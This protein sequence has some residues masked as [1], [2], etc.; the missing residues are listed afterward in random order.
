MRI[1]SPVF[2]DGEPLPP[3]YTC[4]GEGIHPELR[5]EEVP[6]EAKSL[7]LIVE[8]PDAPDGPFA[9][10]LLWNIHPMIESIPAGTV[11][12]DAVEGMN[13]AEKPGWHP[14]CP[15]TGDGTHH[16]RFT[17]YA[18]K[19]MLD[20]P[21]DVPRETFDAEIASHLIDTASLTATYAR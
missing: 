8:D 17:L 16:Y 21:P 18:L 6:E 1:V 20:L 19:S 12:D 11:P 5:F 10:W 4:D 3:T 14:A 9:H 7:A 13:G 2:N 15:P